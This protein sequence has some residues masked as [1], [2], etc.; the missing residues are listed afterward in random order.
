VKN[1]LFKYI[2][3]IAFL[4]TYLTSCKSITHSQSIGHCIDPSFKLAF[5]T[6]ATAQPNSSPVTEVLPGGDWRIET[7]VPNG[8]VS[9]IS[10]FVIRGKN[11]LWLTISQNV[12]VAVYRYRIDT[13]EWTRFISTS[14]E[15]V[16][17]QGLIVSSDGT[18]WGVGWVDYKLGQTHNNSYPILSQFDDVA[19]QFQFIEGMSA[20]RRAIFR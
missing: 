20:H 18:L 15:P 1:K 9:S 6:Y 7:A 4:S 11:E 12:N 19:E 3:I 16:V 2:C 13:H 10:S 5:P 14:N 8:D 17:P